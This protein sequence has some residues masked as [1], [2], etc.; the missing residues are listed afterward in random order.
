MFVLRPESTLIKS[1][2]HS[3]QHAVYNV[4]LVRVWLRIA[5][6]NVLYIFTVPKVINLATST[7]QQLAW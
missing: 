7:F 1:L 4:A 2:N 3:H 5:H 6:C